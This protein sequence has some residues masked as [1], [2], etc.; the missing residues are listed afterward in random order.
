MASGNPTILQDHSDGTGR[1]MQMGNVGW[2]CVWSKRCYCNLPC[3]TV[4]Q[5]VTLAN[6][7]FLAQLAQLF[8][9]A[10]QNAVC[11]RLRLRICLDV[12]HSSTNHNRCTQ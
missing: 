7:Q 3:T 6:R 4:V 5:S 8:I 2:N 9:E 12:N 10:G 11:L 1:S